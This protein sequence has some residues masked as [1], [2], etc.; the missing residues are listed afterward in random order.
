MHVFAQ[1]W[2]NY[3]LNSLKKSKTG[4][5]YWQDINIL[6]ISCLEIDVSIIYGLLNEIKVIYKHFDTMGDIN[7]DSIFLQE[8]WD[9]SLSY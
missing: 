7:I 5:F 2:R 3:V 1:K 4:L 8:E 6:K 9:K